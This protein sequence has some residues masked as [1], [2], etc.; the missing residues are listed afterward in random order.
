MYQTDHP[1]VPFPLQRLARFYRLFWSLKIANDWQTCT[2]TNISNIQWVPIL[3]QWVKI[4]LEVVGQKG[5]GPSN[6]L[7]FNFW[8]FAFF[9][10]ERRNFRMRPHLS[11]K[12]HPVFVSPQE[13]LHYSV[14][15]DTEPAPGCIWTWRLLQQFFTI[16][17]SLD[18]W[19]MVPVSIF[20]MYSWSIRSNTSFVK[21]QHYTDR[22]NQKAREVLFNF[23]STFVC[24]TDYFCPQIA[25]LCSY[26]GYLW[27]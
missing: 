23:Q 21:L 12:K 2:C 25:T 3:P 8:T 26:H 18:Q 20:K 19:L 24:S 15:F 22:I 17:L 11:H 10:E 16:S 27:I 1:H 9:F 14:Y 4:A 13:G 5:D 7:H 6:L